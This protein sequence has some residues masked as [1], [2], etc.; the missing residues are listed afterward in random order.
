MMK[1][2]FVILL[3]MVML[4]AFAACAADKPVTTGDAPAD[5]PADTGDTVYEL[6]WALA[7]PATDVVNTYFVP[8]FI[9]EIKERTNGRVIITPYAGGELLTIATIYDG[10]VEGVADIGTGMYSITDSRF[11]RISIFD[12]PGFQ[13][14]NTYVSNMVAMDTYNEYQECFTDHQDTHVLWIDTCGPEYM[15]TNKRVEEMSDLKGLTIRGSGLIAKA[16]DALGITVVSLPVTDAYSSLEKNVI[17]GTNDRWGGS[18]N[19]G[20]A[21]V[22]NYLLFERVIASTVTFCNVMNLDT[23]NSLP[24]DIQ[25]VF[26][27]MQYEC[28]EKSAEGFWNFDNEGVKK[29]G[30][31]GITV[32]TFSPEELDKWTSIIDE[33]VRKP[34]VEANEAADF[35][36]T[37]ILDFMQERTDYY[38]GIYPETAPPSFSEYFPDIAQ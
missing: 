27:D 17:D 20:Y 22:V 16:M 14:N 1:K 32:L 7:W 26:T 23:W 35:P 31:E 10:V 25:Q 33:K 8:W 36:A 4:F 28:V 13:Y 21:E 24:A 6:T 18:I 12:M 9:E 15:W 38:N 3:A 2:V 11:P 5:T 37:E 29:A 30:E 34:Y 19:Y